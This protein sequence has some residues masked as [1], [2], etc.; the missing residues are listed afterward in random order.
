MDRGIVY[1]GSIPQDT[2]IL[3]LNRRAMIAL[4]Y[5]AQMA[6]GTST[7]VDGL[8]CTPTS[9]ATLTVNVGLG[10]ILSLEEI[11]PNSYGS[12]S[13]DTNALV[14]MGINAESSTPFTLTAPTT[15]GDSI[16]Y[17]IEA[18]FQE[19]DV[20]PVVLPYYNAANP[21][22][23]YSGPN[24][25]GAAQNTLREE[26]VE[27]QLKAGAAA[28]TGTQ[29]TPA[30][31]TGW[32][33]LYVITVNYGQTQITSGDIT[34]HSQAPFILTKIPLISISSY[35]WTDTG[36]ANAYAAT[37]R[38]NLLAHELGLSIKV[39]ITNTNTGPSTFNPGPGAV[40]II[41]PNGGGL[42]PGDLPASAIATFVYDGTYYQLISVTQYTPAPVVGGTSNLV[43]SASGTTQTASWTIDEIIA[44]TAL[45]G[46][47][48]IGSSLTFNFNGAT[49]GAGGMDTGTLS[50]SAA[51]D[52]A[53]YAIYNPTTDTWNTLGYNE[54]AATA[55]PIYPGTNMPAGYTAS[56]LIWAGVTSSSGLVQN[57]I[58]NGRKIFTDE[59][60]IIGGAVNTTYTSLSLG[61]VVPR[62]AIAWFVGAGLTVAS[63]S[64]LYLSPAASNSPGYCVIWG[65]N[66]IAFG[67]LRV[68]ITTAQQTYYAV[69]SG[70]NWNIA[71][72]GYEI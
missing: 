10:S 52:L 18:T 7:V 50:T 43:G 69:S 36:T 11:D 45:G 59:V 54:A 4:G 47:A 49:T 1:P 19:S 40:T 58:Q 3:E 23:P 35:L 6:L 72:G 46:P 9:P 64:N 63:A 38:P 44:K 16:N 56:C 29:T 8:A 34:T 60:Q 71:V 53:I 39:K 37:L 55:T 42:Q 30:V 66:S 2:D 22:Q 61:S 20:T 65:S 70:S 25:T 48:Y 51:T 67:Y 68:A 33:G 5:L 24:N 27:L 14:K 62:S 21:S 41:R 26:I 32:V 17:L 28:P 13:A 15:S 31:D 12:L 57:F